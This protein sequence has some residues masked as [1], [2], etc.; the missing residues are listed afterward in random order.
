M[1]AALLGYLFLALCL[2]YAQNLVVFPQVH[3]RLLSLLVFYLASRPSLGLALAL[4]FSLGALQDSFAITPFGLHIGAA[5]V[6]VAVARFFRQ[7]LLWQ[8][9]GPQVVASLVGLVLQEL[10]LL[11][12]TA[13]LGYEGF[14]AWDLLTRHAVEILGTAALGPLLYLLVRGLEKFLRQFGWRPLSDT[15]SYQ[16]Y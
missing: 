9:L 2:F 1:I 7:R 13:V 4:A 10:F 6:L 14:F 12:S 15:S 16:P 11:V 3:L 8:R 5:L